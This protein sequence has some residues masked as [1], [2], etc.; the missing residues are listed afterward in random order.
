[1]NKETDAALDALKKAAQSTSP[2]FDRVD[3][4]AKKALDWWNSD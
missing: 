1:V 3:D 4:L 2:V